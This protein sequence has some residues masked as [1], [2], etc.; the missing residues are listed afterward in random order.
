[1]DVRSSRSIHGVDILHKLAGFL[2]PHFK[3]S[4]YLIV[5]QIAGSCRGD[6]WAGFRRWYWINTDACARSPGRSRPDA[7]NR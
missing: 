6:G 2:I 3:L 5:G 7:P 4:H 1:M